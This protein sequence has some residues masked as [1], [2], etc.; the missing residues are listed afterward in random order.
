VGWGAALPATL[1]TTSGRQDHVGPHPI[2][3]NGVGQKCF[4]MNIVANPATFEFEFTTTTPA[5][6]FLYSKNALS[7]YTRSKFLQRWFCNS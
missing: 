3:M 5:L 4:N 7:Y 6:F 1:P 2:Q